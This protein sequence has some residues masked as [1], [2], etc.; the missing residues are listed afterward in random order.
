[1]AHPRGLL[2]APLEQQSLT[3]KAGEDGI[4]LFFPGYQVVLGVKGCTPS[5]RPVHASLRSA[6]HGEPGA[7][8]R[9]ASRIFG[10]CPSIRCDILSQ[11]G[12]ARPAANP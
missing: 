4:A 7:R 5:G 9:L 10:N 6:G 11:I 8:A 2:A 1:M 3:A 12:P